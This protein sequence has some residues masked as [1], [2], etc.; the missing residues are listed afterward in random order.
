MAELPGPVPGPD[1]RAGSSVVG[2]SALS[3]EVFD[4][5]GAVGPTA[6]GPTAMDEP[7]IS[8]DGY[9]DCRGFSRSRSS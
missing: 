4:D 9:V 7:R 3:R 8:H 5:G 2:S 1:R 6:G